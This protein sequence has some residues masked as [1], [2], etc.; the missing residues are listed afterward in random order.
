V[1]HGPAGEASDFFNSLLEGLQSVALFAP[2]YLHLDEA[3]RTATAAGDAEQPALFLG[4]RA[5][6]GES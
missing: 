3:S 5:A 4:T 2:G 6:G 1:N